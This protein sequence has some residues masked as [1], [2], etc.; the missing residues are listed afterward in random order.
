M[1]L[2]IA[3]IMDPFHKLDSIDEDTSCAL[4]TESLERG[5]KVYYLQIKDLELQANKAWGNA[6]KINTRA[7]HAF[8]MQNP[9]MLDLNIFHAIFMR[10]D[11][12]F[13]LDYLYATYILEH[14]THALV[15]NRPQGIRNANEKLYAL[16]FPE[17]VPR[18]LVSKNPQALK[19]FL[20]QLGGEMVVKPLNN[21]SGKEILYVRKDDINVN[22]MLEIATKEGKRFV[23]GQEFLPQVKAG[24]KRILLLEG[25]PLGAMCRVPPANDYRANIHRG[26][27]Y[28]Q[29]EI[30]EYERHICQSLSSRLLK[31]GIYFAGIDLIDG[32]II[33]INVTSPAGIPEINQLAK[34]CLEKTVIDWLEQKVSLI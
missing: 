11:P 8:A 14:V 34:T 20:L 21:C 31:D 10:K 19:K 13:N 12:P 24:D 9:E 15:I 28:V 17:F 32:K 5:H 7:K 18:S 2:N 26:A 16:N 4:I 29:A 27:T 30:T 1:S 25:K 6:R 23:I 33:E 3:F 22:S